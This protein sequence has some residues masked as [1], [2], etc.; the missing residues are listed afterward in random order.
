MN[1]HAGFPPIS[2]VFFALCKSVDT[3]FALGAWIRFKSDHRSLLDL[4]INPCNYED[5]HLFK[6][7]Y[8]IISFLSKYKG[9]ITGYDL[10]KE[11]LSKFETSE[12]LC[13][14]TNLRIRKGRNLGIKAELSTIIS[15]AQRKIAFLLGPYSTFK[16]S[17]SYGWG[18]GATS[19]ISRRCA[20]VDTKLSQTPISVTRR[21]LPIIRQEISGDLH[22]SSVLIGVEVNDI[23]GNFC[24]L[25]HVFS[26]SEECVVDTVPKNSKTHRV[27][28]KENTCNG[29]L[30]KGFGAFF[31]T[32]LERVGIHLDD[33]SHNQRAA[34]A[35]YFDDLA[36]LDLKAASDT[37]AKELVFELLPID[38][39]LALDDVRSHS[40]LMP[41]GTKRTLQKFSS[42]GNGF[43]FELETLI[44]W[45]LSSSVSDVISGSRRVWVYGDDIVCPRDSAPLLIE[46]LDYCGFT[47]NSEKSFVSGNF[48]ESCGKHYFKGV[49]VTPIYQKEMVISYEELIRLGNRLIRCAHRF[50]NYDSLDKRIHAAWSRAWRDSGPSCVFQLP[51][52][53]EGDDG[54]VVP[55]DYFTGKRHDVNHGIRCTVIRSAPKRLPALESALLAWTLRRG[56]VTQSPYGGCVT[57]SP[58]TTKSKTSLLLRGGRWVMPTWE[59]GLSW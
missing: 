45:A 15:M 8:L 27:I 51:L 20:F 25:P 13:Q 38:W 16:V 59:F 24:F 37:V 34:F 44:F 41:D 54:W 30:Q 36:T 5:P 23:V 29:F 12:A 4:A 46:V 3:P 17:D 57:S 35:A 26:V 53:T 43:T 50:G 49:D 28:A 32:R 14:E 10:E 19:D 11:A 31:R 6:A 1:K 18:P 48:F 56:V 7:D 22:W 21:A 9:L 58:D 39:A 52:G 47:V 33:Q 2:E 40:A 42:M 55:A